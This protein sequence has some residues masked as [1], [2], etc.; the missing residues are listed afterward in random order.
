MGDIT[1][2]DGKKLPAFLKGKKDSLT[3]SLAGSGG[4]GL[5]RRRIS[6]EG[7]AFR[8][9]INGKE[10]YV[11][12]ESSLDI[13]IVN[14]APS[15]SRQYYEGTYV[16]GQ[17]TAPTCWSSDGQ[18]PDEKVKNK[19]SSI[20][21]K[22]PQNIKGSGQGDSR[23][24]RYQQRLAV[25]LSGEAEKRE[26]YQLVLPA[27]SIFGKEENGKMPLQAYAQ[28]LN[29]QG[30]DGIPIWGVVTT[31]R[32][33]TSASTPKLIF[34]PRRPITDEEYEIIQELENSPEAL[35]AIA[36]TVAQTDGVKDT[37]APRAEPKVEAPKPKPTPVEEDEEDEIEPPKKTASKK[38]AVDSESP[39]IADLLGDDWDD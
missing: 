4:S 5:T 20:C 39:N 9:I 10:Q 34:R 6:I 31:M 26:V 32:F 18:R 37:P 22:C 30:E 25:L 24:C 1:I 29:E 38:A 3:Q 23:A 16:R 7:R 36:L 21:A 17:A 33:D 35:D 27:T 14:A 28:F 15:V 2:F 8:Q 12:E 11:S 19:Q 13:L